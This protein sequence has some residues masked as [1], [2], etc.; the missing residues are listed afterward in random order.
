MYA[1]VLRFT[2]SGRGPKINEILIIKCKHIHHTVKEKYKI[3]KYTFF[4]YTIAISKNL[5]IDK[6][7][8]IGEKMQ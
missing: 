7:Q 8:G 2:H 3:Y 4:K 6:L 1:R 5:C